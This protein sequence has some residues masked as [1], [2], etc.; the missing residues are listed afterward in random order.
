MALRQGFVCVFGFAMCRYRQ[1]GAAACA[2]SSC[3]NQSLTGVTRYIRAQFSPTGHDDVRSSGMNV[4]MLITKHKQKETLGT[5]SKHAYH[6]YITQKTG[7]CWDVLSRTDLTC[8]I[9]W[10]LIEFIT[11]CYWNVHAKK[12]PVDTLRLVIVCWLCRISIEC[13]ASSMLISFIVYH[14]SPI[15]NLDITV[16]FI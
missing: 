7:N 10:R 13:T 14:L 8:K 11:G 16:T 4:F 1:W 6:S 3:I 9:G 15:W 2:T 5:R 12:K